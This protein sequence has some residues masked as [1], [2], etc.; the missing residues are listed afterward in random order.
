MQDKYRFIVALLVS[1]FS[2]TLGSIYTNPSIPWYQELLKPWFQV[3]GWVFGPVWL[4]LYG[5]IG[6]AIYLVWKSKN[7]RERTRALTLFGFHLILS[8]V[9]TYLFWKLQNTYF[10]YIEITF[11]WL[12]LV[13]SMEM[14]WNLNKRAFYLLLPYLAWLSYAC[15]L[16]YAIWQLNL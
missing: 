2:G 11:V 10:A 1:Y 13:I 16:N 8:V 3:P 14:F 4:I 15:M 5:L 12:T 7:V 9:W 6:Y